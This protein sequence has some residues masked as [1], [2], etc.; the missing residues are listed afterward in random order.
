MVKIWDGNPSKSEIIGR[1]G[2]DEKKNDNAEPT[3]TNKTKQTNK[4]TQKTVQILS[5][6]V[7]NYL[8]NEFLVKSRYQ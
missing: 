8:F 1:C 2:G 5:K 7:S 6:T 3:K 4:T